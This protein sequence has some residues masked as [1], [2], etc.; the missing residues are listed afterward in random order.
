MK[1]LCNLNRFLSLIR[2]L[3]NKFRGLSPFGS[4]ASLLF[5]QE[6]PKKLPTTA[7]SSLLE[8]HLMVFCIDPIVVYFVNCLNLSCFQQLAFEKPYC[9]AEY[10][11]EKMMNCCQQSLFALR[12]LIQTKLALLSPIPTRKGYF[13]S[14]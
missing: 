3:N 13:L 11:C 2:L 5:D 14:P 10:C 6:V 7:P 9:T 1:K 8:R 4:C 12:H